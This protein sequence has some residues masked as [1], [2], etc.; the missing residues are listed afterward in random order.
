MEGKP[1]AFQSYMPHM[2]MVMYVLLHIIRLKL[3]QLDRF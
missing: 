2:Y 3:S 1:V